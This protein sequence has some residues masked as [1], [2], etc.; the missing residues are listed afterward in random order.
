VRILWFSNSPRVGT[1]YGV[2]TAEVVP[3]LQAA[4]HEVAVHSNW[5][6][7]AEM[8]TFGE[9]PIFPNGADPYGNDIAQAHAEEFRADWTIT[10]YDTWTL[11]RDRWPANVA[12]WVPIDHQPVPPKVAEWCRKVRPIA[13]SRFGQKMLRDQG[14][15]STYIPHSLDTSIFKPTEVTRSGTKARD[16]FGIPDDAFLISIFA[17]NQGVHPPRKAWGQMFQALSV[18]LAAHPDA[19]VYLHTDRVGPNKGLDL[20]ILGRAAGL[21]LERIRY[22][23]RYA[24]GTNRITQADLAALYSMGDV[25]LASSMGEGFGIPVIEAQACGLPVIVSDF[26]AQ[27]ELCES[28]WLVKGQGWW[29][30][31][32]SSWFFDPYVPS[33]VK[34]LEAAYAARG[35]NGLRERAVAFAAAYDSDLVFERYWLP[36]L[37]ELEAAPTGVMNREE[38]RNQPCARCGKP[39]KS[40]S[41]AKGKTLG[42]HQHFFEEKAA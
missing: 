7:Y 41:H 17:A 24:Y 12:S 39:R 19:W 37:A 42:G 13:M 1:G 38:R 10:L 26:S 27:P 6:Q 23:H 21:P 11:E 32:Q 3:R 9:I 22:V 8:V 14:I 33:I 15:D 18:F 30:E 5:P 2:Q 29:D 35:D 31:A 40:G 20:D 4:G 25:M 28:G 16:A 34:N 36:F